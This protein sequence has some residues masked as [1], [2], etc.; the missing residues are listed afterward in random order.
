MTFTLARGTGKPM[1]EKGMARTRP[2]YAHYVERTSG[3][4]PLPPRKVTPR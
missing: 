1:L 2:A 3:F 4:F